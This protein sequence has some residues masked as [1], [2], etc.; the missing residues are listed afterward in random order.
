MPIIYSVR[1]NCK[2][3]T[4]PKQIHAVMQTWIQGSNQNSSGIIDIDTKSSHDE[5]S[6]GQG[7]FTIATAFH[8]TTKS[9]CTAIRSSTNLLLSKNAPPQETNLLWAAECISEE[10]ADGIHFDINLS[11]TVVNPEQSADL[12][13]TPIPPRIISLLIKNDLL[14]PDCGIPFTTMFHTTQDVTDA[15][16]ADAAAGRTL[17]ELPLVLVSETNS[18]FAHALA[19]A[20]R[21]TGHIFVLP[22][23]HPLREGWKADQV[24]LL[25][26]RANARKRYTIKRGEAQHILSDVLRLT[27]FAFPG[28]ALTFDAVDY[29]SILQGGKQAEHAPKAGFICINPSMAE[30]MRFHRKKLGLTQAEL[31]ERVGSTG[32]IISRVENNKTV[33]ITEQLLTDIERELGLA[34]GAFTAM[35]TLQSKPQEKSSPSIQTHGFCYKCGTKLPDGSIFCHACGTKLPV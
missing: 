21:G 11:R 18:L 5:V 16:L 2:P 7:V 24:L 25:Y 13:K 23:D 10:T 15:A 35:E 30:A 26:P 33:R 29:W 20:L 31:G 6:N 34:S 28:K 3:G 22:D 8:P 14:E 4:D 27:Y 1:L 32:L 17:T 12:E 19:G 9:R